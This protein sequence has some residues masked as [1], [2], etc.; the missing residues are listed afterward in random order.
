MWLQ[1]LEGKDV[2]DLLTSVGSGGG[3]AAPAAGAAAGGAAAA[4]EAPKEEAKAEGSYKPYLC[5]CVGEQDMNANIRNRKG[6]VRRRHGIRSVRLSGFR[7]NSNCRNDDHHYHLYDD[8]LAVLPLKS[9]CIGLRV[10][11]IPSTTKGWRPRYMVAGNWSSANMMEPDLMIRCKSKEK[12]APQVI[13]PC[14]DHQD[15]IATFLTVRFG[16]SMPQGRTC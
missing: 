14:H 4:E 2:K 12:F 13:G 8:F 10:F 15:K 9:L 6:G 7:P 16:N 11:K 3:A 1:A 5:D